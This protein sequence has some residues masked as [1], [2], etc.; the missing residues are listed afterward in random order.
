[1]C[2]AG[3][4]PRQLHI[5]IVD[6]DELGIRSAQPDRHVD[7]IHKRLEGI[8]RS[9]QTVAFGLEFGKF[10]A[11]IRQGDKTDKGTASGDPAL[12]LDDMTANGFN[13]HVE[14]FRMGT[15]PINR[16]VECCCRS[17]FQPASES[18]EIGR[19]LGRSGFGGELAED[20]GGQA[21][22]IPDDDLPVTVDDQRLVAR[23]LAL[24]SAR[25]ERSST[26]SRSIL[27]RSRI[28]QMAEIMAA[29]MA[30]MTM[31]KLTTSRVDTENRLDEAASPAAWARTGSVEPRK[32]PVSRAVPVRIRRR[33]ER[34]SPITALVSP[35]S[36]LRPSESV[37]TGI[38]QSPRRLSDRISPILASPIFAPPQRKRIIGKKHTCFANHGEEE[39]AQ[40]EIAPLLSRTRS[41]YVV[42][43]V[44]KISSGSVPA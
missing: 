1:M 24:A 32:L 25:A 39:A 15:Q 30:P 10:C 22:A 29:E 41:Q 14:A 21:D 3:P 43:S 40:K 34:R 31:A 44:K 36:P 35:E 6:P 33:N 38:S 12:R 11:H 20:F 26:F 4:H 19:I 37:F 28:S 5:G 18:E 27:P 23:H 8:E 17:G 9:E 13:D 2:P 7:D 16:F 42:G